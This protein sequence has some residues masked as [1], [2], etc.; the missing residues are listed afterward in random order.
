MSE[1]FL[2]NEDIFAFL[3]IVP[4]FYSF[5]FVALYVLPFRVARA[6]WSAKVLALM[7]M[8]LAGVGTL[9]MIRDAIEEP[10]PPDNQPTWLVWIPVTAIGYLAS[11]LLSA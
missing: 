5:C 11:W 3:L 7:A 10:Y 8:A 9:L 4:A 2:E 1:F 6:N